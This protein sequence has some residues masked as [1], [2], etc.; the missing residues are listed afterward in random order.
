M[1]GVNENLN[2]LWDNRSSNRKDSI[3]WVVDFEN[4][5]IR[6]GSRVD[7]CRLLGLACLISSPSVLIC[8]SK[9]ERA[10]PNDKIC[11]ISTVALRI[12]AH[13]IRQQRYCPRRQET[14]Y[15]NLRTHEPGP[16]RGAIKTNLNVSR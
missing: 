3:W 15:P 7:E 4:A 5:A 9:A 2:V 14:H 8:C 11:A 10:R 1:A 13:P 6:E 12:T 16:D